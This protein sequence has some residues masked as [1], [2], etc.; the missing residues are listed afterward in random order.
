MLFAGA[1]PCDAAGHLEGIDAS[2]PPLHRMALVH[3]TGAMPD[4]GG[5]VPV[6]EVVTLLL[7]N[8]DTDKSDMH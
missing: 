3:C 6:L 4:N 5:Q 7:P 2:A 1:L 8:T